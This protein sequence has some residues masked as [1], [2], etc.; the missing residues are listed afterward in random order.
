MVQKM[1]KAGN[2]WEYKV[3]INAVIA[4]FVCLRKCRMESHTLHNIQ[5]CI[6]EQWCHFYNFHMFESN[7]SVLIRNPSIMKPI[8]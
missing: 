4:N 6:S 2:I 1:K 3:E 7:V 8:G 5:N